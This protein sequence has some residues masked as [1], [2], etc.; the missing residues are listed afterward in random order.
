MQQVK[1]PAVSFKKLETPYEDNGQKDYMMVV[2]LKRLPKIEDKW[3]E[4][5]PRHQNVSSA[6]SKDI[7]ETLETNPETFYFKNRGLTILA[8]KVIYDNKK[9]EVIIELEDNKIHGLLDGGHSYKAII[10][11]L[12][13]NQDFMSGSFVKVEVLEGF[14][15]VD[16]VVDLVAARNTSAQVKD[17]SLFDLRDYFKDIKM[18]LAAEPAYCDNI[19]YKEFEL[20]DENEKKKELSI[21]DILSYL[22]CFDSEEYS[23]TNHPIQAY[24]SKTATL[25][26]YEKHRKRLSKYITLLPTILKLWDTI[27]KEYPKVYAGK[28][29][30]LPGVKKKNTKLYFLD[31]TCEYKIPRGY[32]YPILASFRDLIVCKKDRCEF[33]TDPILLFNEKTKSDLV[34]RVIDRVKEIENP[35]KLVKERL[36]WQACADIVHFQK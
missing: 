26:Y 27:Q 36:L 34:T 14:K 15:E 28:M 31:D 24:S 16:E 5:N 33:S 25:D 12:E 10:N 32:I 13:E 1:F 17:V 6:V 4:I 2:N 22:I 23:W 18:V 20:Q 35:N 8:K 21:Q 29:G 30:S 11:H 7:K 19:A 3:F 9:E